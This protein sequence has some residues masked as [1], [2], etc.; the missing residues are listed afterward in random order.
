MTSDKSGDSAIPYIPPSVS[1]RAMDRSVA[2]SIVARKAPK[3]VVWAEDY[4]TAGDVEAAE[5][6]LQRY[7]EGEMVAAFGMFEVLDAATDIVIGGIGFH[8]P[9]DEDGRVE[10][11]Y[12]IVPS[13]W[14]QGFGTDALEET[15]EYAQAHGARFVT[16]RTVPANVA[17][18]R[19]LEKAGFTF[20]DVNE[21][22]ATYEIRLRA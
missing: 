19:I 20:I 17:S 22:Y 5:L 4:P 11:G 14:D 12:G 15:V 18:R 16:A 8:R 2:R 3:G 10:V 6:L 7:R 1:L 21:G 13:R 9:P